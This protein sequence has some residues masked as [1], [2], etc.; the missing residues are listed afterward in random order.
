[1]KTTQNMIHPI[2][3]NTQFETNS[4]SESLN[5]QHRLYI[6]DINTQTSMRKFRRKQ[7]SLSVQM[8]KT[9]KAIDDKYV[10]GTKLTYKASGSSSRNKNGNIKRPMNAF[11]VFGRTY[12]STLMKMFPTAS[13]SQISIYLG[14]IWH[15]MSPAQQKPY[16]DES[17]RIKYKHRKDYPGWVYRP[18]IRQRFE[19]T[20]NDIQVDNKLT[21]SILP[22]IICDQKQQIP[23]MA[24]IPIIYPLS[25]N[26]MTLTMPAEGSI[27]SNPEPNNL[28]NPMLNTEFVSAN[29][30]QMCQDQMY[31][32]VC[33]WESSWSNQDISASSYISPWTN[34]RSVVS[35]STA[36]TSQGL[37]YSTKYMLSSAATLNANCYSPA[38]LNDQIQ[39][40]PPEYWP[41]EEQYK[42]QQTSSM[43]SFQDLSSLST[44]LKTDES[45]ESNENLSFLEYMHGQEY[46]FNSTM[47]VSEEPF[48]SPD[49]LSPILHKCSDQSILEIPESY[50]NSKGENFFSVKDL[51]VLDGLKEKLDDCLS[52]D[53]IPQL[54]IGRWMAYLNQPEQFDEQTLELFF[55]NS[56]DPELTDTY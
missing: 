34:L 30:V 27:N 23:Q 8:N 2:H 38:L 12:R 56:S 55:S 26:T 11:M 52:V 3:G 32:D 45:S 6:D 39:S 51:D 47:P 41:L 4:T 53:N 16:F 33:S 46:L 54:D 13:N 50:S 5:N 31:S 17:N 40:N 1:M 43:D 44:T 19:G 15:K 42:T 28:E 22:K 20:F 35:Y 7:R 36:E 37:Q 10:P 49:K 21:E 29:S 25:N 14:E 18:N 24:V 48:I 9:E